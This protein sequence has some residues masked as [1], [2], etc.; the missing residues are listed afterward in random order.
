MQYRAFG[1][2]GLEVSVLGYGCGA[3]GGLM[4]RGTHREMIRTVDYALESG[5]NY[6]DTARMY[7]DGLSEI[8]TGAI[9]RELGAK[10]AL[11]GTKVRLAST[12]FDDIETVIEAQIEN[13]LLRLGRD[14]VDIVYTHNSIGSESD[15]D[16]GRLS[17]D[18]LERIVAVFDRAVQSGKIRFWGFNGLGDT[19]TIHEAIDKFNPSGMHTCYNMLNPSSS[20]QMVEGFPFQDYGQLMQKTAEK[21]IGSV[22]IRVLAGGALSGDPARH[23]LAAQDVAPIASGQTLSEDFARTSQFRFLVDDGYAENLVEAA[24]RFAISTESLS[25]ALVG[26]SSFEQLEQAVT[27]TNKGPL[28]SDALERLEGIWAAS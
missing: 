12:E 1:N 14:N 17:L 9:L 16:A 25:T 21:G 18:D 8:T 2:T 20:Y 7:G 27:A 28:P 22:A 15:P 24:I 26:L 19:Q 4:V 5:I 6:F 23:P 13:S 3:V 10:D 11:V